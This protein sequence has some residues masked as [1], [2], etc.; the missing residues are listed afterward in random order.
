MN[1]TVFDGWLET[2]GGGERQV[3]AAA[4]ALREI[5]LVT[6]VSH[7]SIE[8]SSV[9]ERAGVDLDGIE[10]RRV[11]E[12]PHLGVEDLGSNCQLFVNG[13]HHSLVRGEGVPSVRFVYFPARVPEWQIR[14]VGGWVRRLG[15]AIG[16]AQ[17]STGWYGSEHNGAGRYRQSD[18]SGHVAVRAGS[19]V[20]FWVSAMGPDSRAYMIT[21]THAETLVEGE[22]GEAGDFSPSPWVSVPDDDGVIVKSE[23]CVSPS[24]GE[25]RRLGVALGSIEERGR[26]LRSGF[27][28]LTR[29]IAPSLGAWS[30]DDSFDRYRQ[31]LASYGVVTPNSH[32]TADW[33]KR[34]WGITGPVI[35]PPVITGPGSVGIKDPLIVSIGR[36]F[37]GGHNKKHLEMVQVFR[38]LCAEGLVGWRLALVGG[39]GHR[40]LDKTYLEQVQAAARGMPIDIFP[41]AGEELV[42]DLRGRAAI[43]WHAAGYGESKRRHPERFEHFGMAIAELMAAGAAP[44]VYDGGGL[45][46]IVEHGHSGFRWRSLDELS[47]WTLSLIR[48]GREREL[49]ASRAQE[50]ASTW[51]LSVYQGRILK[52][53]SQ[54]IEEKSATKT[55]G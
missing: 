42:S 38:Q 2:L 5:G 37:A 48:N 34:R 51:S 15:L 4:G 13:T 29:R 55:V 47:R 30:F 27:H 24:S 53:A 20:R 19:Q 41:D 28:R 7:R 40:S 10:Y 9:T 17:E 26:P 36:F 25:S 21:S 1:I 16:A 49:I 32:Y 39:V 22:A 23:A 52:L 31:A 45:R 50:R 54:L 6:V 33:L 18:G 43:G 3:L 8:W 44:V 12:K 35:E 46:E 11:A 14:V